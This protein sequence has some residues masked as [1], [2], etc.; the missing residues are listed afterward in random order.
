[1][2]LEIAKLNGAYAATWSFATLKFTSKLGLNGSV[3]VTC[4]CLETDLHRF[5]S[6]LTEVVLVSDVDP[7]VKMDPAL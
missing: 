5:I 2:Q 1:M 6:G 4:K 3:L 7:P